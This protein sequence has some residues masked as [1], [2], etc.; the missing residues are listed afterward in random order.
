MFPWLEQL[1]SYYKYRTFSRISRPAY[2]SN[3][4]IVL[5]KV[6][7]IKKIDVLKTIYI[8][9][10]VQVTKKIPILRPHFM[11]HIYVK[12]MKF[13]QNFVQIS[14]LIASMYVTLF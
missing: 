10:K 5:L 3:W 11:T 6:S 9:Y 14:R 1:F 12:L 2:K 7:K 8:A 4:K 13:C